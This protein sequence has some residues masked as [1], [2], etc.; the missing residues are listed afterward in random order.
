[1]GITSN[2][3]FQNGSYLFYLA[4]LP[5]LDDFTTDLIN[6]KRLTVGVFNVYVRSVKVELSSYLR[7]IHQTVSK[8]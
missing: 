5:F 6:R 1:M 3:A 4:F 7:I 8:W 2:S